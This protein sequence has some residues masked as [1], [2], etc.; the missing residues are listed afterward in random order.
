MD[1]NENN[2]DVEQLNT[3]SSFN[4]GNELDVK[5]YL[6]ETG[7][8]NIFNDYNKSI[9][10][11]DN[12]KQKEVQD[13]YYIR[14]LSKKYLG[15][16]ASNQGI[17]DVSADLLNIYGSYQNNL[18]TINQYYTDLETGL[19]SSY[20][21]KKN[22]YELGLLET[23]YQMK[24]E[25]EAKELE[26]KLAEISY[27]LSTE[28][29]P[30][31]MDAMG[32][33]DSVKDVIGASNYWS[34]ASEYKLNEM[35]NTVNSALNSVGD[36]S[37]QEEWDSYI[38]SLVSNKEINANYAKELKEQYSLQWG[39]TFTLDK[40]TTNTMDISY[41]FPNNMNIKENGKVYTSKDNKTMLVETKNVIDSTSSAYEQVDEKGKNIN[42]NTPFGANG[43]TWVKEIQGGEQVYVEYASTSNV[44]N[45]SYS[46]EISSSNDN[47]KAQYKV[48]DK[49]LNKKD[50]I[51][52]TDN[53]K[54]KYKYDS[55]SDSYKPYLNYTA[56]EV[57]SE[58]GK[59]E[60]EGIQ[61]TLD[62]YYKNN[63][64]GGIIDVKDSWKNGTWKNGYQD[65]H[66]A[67]AIVQEMINVYFDGKDS[68][69]SEY[70]EGSRKGGKNKIGTKETLIVK[71]GGSYYTINDG[72][73]WELKKND[74]KTS[75]I[76]DK[77]NEK[78]LG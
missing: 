61:Y 76:P 40:E 17:G 44:N 45:S 7:L 72:E 28:M 4:G 15:E 66:N 27:N 65:V 56:L 47:T 5:K 60:I 8:Q 74:N 50:G 75:T 62:K 48:I 38:D 46:M 3:Y 34:L 35:A 53:G 29:Y 1:N 42:Y 23:E 9:A 6:Y 36:Y 41:F 58:Y 25:Q 39:T 64:H 77:L 54:I 37:T 67:K 69:F 31:G 73:L 2:K 32:Y 70:V 33:L 14:E 71:Y 68:L 18:N 11:L 22:E 43:K 55:E 20:N 51:M 13:A 59:Y 21:E 10:T 78:T 19:E 26:E 49:E 24:Q 63:S 12:A 16:Y 57:K 30:D 52:N